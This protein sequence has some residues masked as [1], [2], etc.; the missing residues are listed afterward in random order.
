MSNR[1]WALSHTGVVSIRGI[2]HRP[3]RG[4]VGS[5]FQRPSR[6]LSSFSPSL[7]SSHLR[8]SVPTF[9]SLYF[10]PPCFFH[11]LFSPSLSVCFLPPRLSPFS[12]HLSVS[13]PVTSPSP[14]LT[15]PVAL[16]L[17]FSAANHHTPPPTP[18][19][20]F[21]LSLLP[22]LYP[23]IITSPLP[24]HPAVS[25]SVPWQMQ[26]LCKDYPVSQYVKETEV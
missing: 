21:T 5:S 19:L 18:L 17:F 3:P 16:F 10:S 26:C 22:S 12:L 25:S 20:S 7:R 8:P 1:S 15:H 14:F 13:L 9:L 4:D 11:S 6:R 24:L 23:L 2:I